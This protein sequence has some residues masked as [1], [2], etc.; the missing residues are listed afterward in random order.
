MGIIFDP[1]EEQELRLDGMDDLG[2]PTGGTPYPAREC[3]SAAFWMLFTTVLVGG[4]IIMVLGRYF[5]G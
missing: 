5:G 1:D 4:T 2:V 3:I